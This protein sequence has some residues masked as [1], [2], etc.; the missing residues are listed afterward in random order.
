VSLISEAGVAGDPRTKCSVLKFLCVWIC[1]DLAADPAGGT[2][3][4]AIS[5]RCSGDIE[6]FSDSSVLAVELAGLGAFVRVSL[7]FNGSRISPSA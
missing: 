7:G 1:G 6:P 3:G 5:D 2:G 4:G